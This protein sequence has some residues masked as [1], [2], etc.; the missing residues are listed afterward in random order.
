MS[1]SPLVGFEK[2][3]NKSLRI[4]RNAP[5]L[6]AFR[7][8]LSWGGLVDDFYVDLEYVLHKSGKCIHGIDSL[9]QTF[10]DKNIL[11]RAPAGYGKTASFKS[12]LSKTAQGNRGSTMYQQPYSLQN[13]RSVLNSPGFGALVRR[14]IQKDHILSK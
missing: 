4:E 3:R 10:G 6:D 5:V 2:A 1:S 12:S 11:L 7:D 9:A 13:G 14:Y 8:D